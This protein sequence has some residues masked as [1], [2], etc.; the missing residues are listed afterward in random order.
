MEFA[1]SKGILLLQDCPTL[2]FPPRLHGEDIAVVDKFSY[3]AARVVITEDV[4]ARIV[5]GSIR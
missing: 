4:S 1:P 3:W 2:P 5:K